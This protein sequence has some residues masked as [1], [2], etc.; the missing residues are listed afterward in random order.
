MSKVWRGPRRGYIVRLSLPLN[1][2][3]VLCRISAF[4]TFRALLRSLCKLSA[5]G[6]FERLRLNH[7]D[8]FSLRTLV[9]LAVTGLAVVTGVEEMLA[10]RG[11]SD[12]E[13]VLG[14]A[15]IS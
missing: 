14:K 10:S 3:T 8:E 15:N 5:L 11:A 4:V 7:V 6:L 2:R 13:E 12:E 9:S 1:Y